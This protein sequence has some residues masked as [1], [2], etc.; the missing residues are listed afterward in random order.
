[1]IWE[2]RFVALR[3]ECRPWRQL[4]TLNIFKTASYGELIY[5]C[6]IENEAE[7]GDSAEYTLIY[8]CSTGVA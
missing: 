2:T 4:F 5:V 3:F 1:M 7:S 8:G 6:T